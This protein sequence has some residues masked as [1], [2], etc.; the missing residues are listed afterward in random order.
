[1]SARDGDLKPSN[2]LEAFRLGLVAPGGGK[3]LFAYIQDYHCAVSTGFFVGTTPGTV[4]GGSWCLEVNNYNTPL[5]PITSAGITFESLGNRHPSGHVEA[6]ELGYN[7]YLVLKNHFRLTVNHIGT[8][9]TDED[10]IV[11]WK[12][13]ASN[14]LSELTTGLATKILTREL[15]H[16]LLST[17]GWKY[18]RFSSVQGGGSVFPATAV[19]D[20]DVAD[21]PKLGMM[22]HQSSSVTDNDYTQFKGTVQDSVAGATKDLN[23]IM[24]CFHID[25]EPM[26]LKSV[27][28]IV[29]S[30]QFVRLYRSI[31][32][33]EAIDE[34]DDA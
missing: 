13:S 2:Y 12:F 16:D 26:D 14:G 33:P 9:A 10:F 19:I 15:F 24:T 29:E 4:T 25:G 8:N 27:S 5:S 3:P 30:K 6:L 20:I 7:T 17:R 21:V 34:G 18:Q 1:M 28:I 32:T 11:A 22:M 31:S 23:L